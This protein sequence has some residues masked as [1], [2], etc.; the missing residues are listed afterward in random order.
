MRVFIVVVVVSHE[1]VRLTMAIQ[2]KK[3]SFP[4]SYQH[5]CINPQGALESPPSQQDGDRPILYRPSA[6]HPSCSEFRG[7]IAGGAQ[8]PRPEATP[9]L[10]PWILYPFL[11]SFLPFRATCS[12]TTSSQHSSQFCDPTLIAVYGKRKL[13]P[14]KL[15]RAL[16]CWHKHSY[17][18][19]NLTG[20]SCPFS[21]T[22]A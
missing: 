1:H 12:A 3:M 6:G 13:L 20:T 5:L 9:T 4:I 16:I 10:P 14:L 19:G 8:K 15:L 2:L 22:A 7:S 21:K 17:S 18:E 11:H